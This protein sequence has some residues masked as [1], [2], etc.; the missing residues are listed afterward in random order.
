[1]RDR[2]ARHEPWDSPTNREA[3]KAMPAVFRSPR[4]DAPEGHT[5]YRAFVGKSAAIPSPEPPADVLRRMSYPTIKGHKLFDRRGRSPV[6]TWP[7]RG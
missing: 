6:S 2:L 3:L 4:G 7:G 1:M 5:Y